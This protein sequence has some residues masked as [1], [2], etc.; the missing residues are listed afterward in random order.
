MGYGKIPEKEMQ[1]TI[2]IIKIVDSF[3]QLTWFYFWKHKGAYI[4]YVV[5]EAGGFYKFFRKTLAA[6]KNIDLNVSWPSNFFRK[7]FIASPIS[8]DF[9]FKTYL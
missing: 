2:T 5:G 8:F 9:L 1:W 7:Y 6:Q 4:K 3:M